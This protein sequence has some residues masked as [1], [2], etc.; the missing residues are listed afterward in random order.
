MAVFLPD[1]SL[2]GMLKSFLDIYLV[3]LW[4]LF[5]EG[6]VDSQGYILSHGIPALHAST[7]GGFG[8]DVTFSH[9]SGNV[10][11]ARIYNEE[12]SLIRSSI[13]VA[14]DITRCLT[15]SPVIENWLKAMSGRHVDGVGADVCLWV[16]WHGLSRVSMIPKTRGFAR[17][18]FLPNYLSARGML[19]STGPL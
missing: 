17:D 14:F 7:R 1:G 3:A 2:S 19:K 9:S 12:R 10:T 5:P 16:L 18:R 4:L 6:W 11:E 15:A 8:Q 13:D